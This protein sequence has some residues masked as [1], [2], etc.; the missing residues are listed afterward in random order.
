MTTV[1]AEMTSAEAAAAVE[2]GTVVLLPVGALEQHGPG[3]PL[4]TDTIRA[5]ALAARVAA[6]LPDAVV[7][8]PSVPVGVSP[9]HLAFAGTVTLTPSTFVTVLREYVDSLARHG[10]RRF[11]VVT[12]HGGNNAALGVL[13]Q[14][15]L[16][17][18]P[19]LELAWAPV[20][21][22]APDAVG[23]L[24]RAEVTGHSGEAETSQVLHVAPHLVRRDLL[25]P[26]TTRT[27]ELDPLSRLAR[28]AG[29]PTL[30]V[31]YD[32]LAA[33]GV[34]GDPRTATAEAGRAIYDEAT[35]RLVAYVKEWLDT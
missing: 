4:G 28:G 26:G 6:E 5:E 7:V 23:D 1:L 21:T 22:L 13:A 8:G 15:L 18:R 14:E 30:A 31:P 9:H 29:P 2:R 16:H 17:A 27:D 34:L 10:W 19:D 35:H 25:E 24:S 32:R 12:G 33:N 11:L 20:T 3:L